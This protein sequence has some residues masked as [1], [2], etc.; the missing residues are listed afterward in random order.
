M[1][2]VIRLI[3]VRRSKVK[4]MA[5][6]IKSGAEGLT[7]YAMQMAKGDADRE[8][9]ACLV[10]KFENFHHFYI[11]VSKRNAAVLKPYV[12]KATNYYKESRDT[13]VKYLVEKRFKTLFVRTN[14]IHN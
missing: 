9:L 2:V 13:Y 8:T 3:V 12:E 6:K 10:L 5:K 1:L 7:N 14:A 4:Q 11:N